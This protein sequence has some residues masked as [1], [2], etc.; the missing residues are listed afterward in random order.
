MKATGRVRG[1]VEREGGRQKGRAEEKAGSPEGR[2][3]LRASNPLASQ[4]AL[5]GGSLRGLA[6]FS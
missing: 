4:E 6:L 5:M 2:A 3:V 1:G